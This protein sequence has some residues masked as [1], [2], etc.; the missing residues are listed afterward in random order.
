[1]TTD[2][3]LALYHE[4]LLHENAHPQHKGELQNPDAVAEFH[5]ASCGDVVRVMI[6]FAP[7]VDSDQVVI[8]QLTWQGHGCAISQAAM[9]LL[10]AELLGKST[11]EVLAYTQKDMEALLGFS[12]ISLGRVKCL[13]L[14]LR[15]VKQALEEA[16]GS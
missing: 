7:P 14:G 13:L 12:T 4:V 3:S 5:N 15:A 1:M 2:D 10:S 8:S 6:A 9:S 16:D 11:Q